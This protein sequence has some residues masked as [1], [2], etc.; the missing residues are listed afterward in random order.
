MTEITKC[1]KCAKNV[2]LKEIKN[3]PQLRFIFFTIFVPLK[4]SHDLPF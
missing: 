3:E 1:P 2:L 4:K